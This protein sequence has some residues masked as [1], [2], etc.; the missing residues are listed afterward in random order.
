MD[1]F[2]VLNVRKTLSIFKDYILHHNHS[3]LQESETEFISV[4]VVPKIPDVECRVDYDCP[5]KLA[6]ID[7]QCQNPCRVSNPCISNQ[8]CVV[9]D[10]LPTRS[11]ACICPDEMVFTD[12]GHCKTGTYI[13][14]L[15]IS[16]YRK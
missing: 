11:V 1:I 4:F 8:K 15:L 10:T 3:K 6:C 14:S 12:Q 5:S 7:E 9:T 13:Y 2:H 16:I